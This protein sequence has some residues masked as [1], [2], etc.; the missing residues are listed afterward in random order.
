MTVSR[1]RDIRGRKQRT[2]PTTGT[3]RGGLY[4]WSV[5]P[6]DDDDDDD[7]HLCYVL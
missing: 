4:P 3:T 6:F 1:I 2:N 5:L 7:V